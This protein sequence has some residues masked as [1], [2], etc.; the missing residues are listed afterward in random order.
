MKVAFK[1]NI[2]LILLMFSSALFSQEYAA[3]DTDN[4]G[5]VDYKEFQEVFRKNF[6]DWDGNEDGILTE[7]EFYNSSFDLIDT[8]ADGML[9][10]DEWDKGFSFVFGDFLGTPHNGQFD[11]NGDREISK[12]EF[13]TSIKFSD[14]FRF[15]DENEDGN[16][17]L[18]EFITGIFAH[19]NEDQNQYIE[20]IE[21]EKFG[22]YFLMGVSEE[23]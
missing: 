20:Q 16:V 17:D 5:V 10:V 19:W 14:F 9:N 2:S 11:L 15:Y 8:N 7:S 22:P 4:N 13:F 1:R 18:N 21:Y 6:S 3:F 23:E 12:K